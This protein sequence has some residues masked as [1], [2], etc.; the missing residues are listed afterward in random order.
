MTYHAH[1]V[2][3]Q[4]QTPGQMTVTCAGQLTRTLLLS[5]DGS[6]LTV[7][8]DAFLRALL[9]RRQRLPGGAGEGIQGRNPVPGGLSKPGSV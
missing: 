2:R 7:G 5:R 8:Q 6:G 3:T 1:D 4:T 9:Q